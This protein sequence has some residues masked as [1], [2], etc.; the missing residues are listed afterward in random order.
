MFLPTIYTAKEITYN[1]SI[2]KL[3]PFKMSRGGILVFLLLS[4]LLFVNAGRPNQNTD[5]PG[6]CPEPTGP[7]ICAII[8][9]NDQECPGVRKCCTTGC[10][11]RACAEPVYIID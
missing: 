8:C 7:G 4:T 1:Q 3:Q 6:N 11:G 2:R 5:K 9:Q 10:G